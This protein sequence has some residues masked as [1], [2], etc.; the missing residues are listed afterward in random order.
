ME[1][2]PSEDDQSD[3]AEKEKGKESDDK[4]DS[5]NSIT[6]LAAPLPARRVSSLV[7][8]DLLLMPHLQESSQYPGRPLFPDS[9]SDPA[10]RIAK[11]P[12]E[13]SQASPVQL[14]SPARSPLATVSDFDAGGEDNAL[15]VPAGEDGKRKRRPADLPTLITLENAANHPLLMSPTEA[16]IRESLERDASRRRLEMMTATATENEK[17]DD[18]MGSPSSRPRSPLPL[19]EEGE[20]EG[21]AILEENI[22]ERQSVRSKTAAGTTRRDESSLAAA[23]QGLAGHPS[24]TPP[25]IPPQKPRPLSEGKAVEVEDRNIVINTKEFGKGKSLNAILKLTAK[26]R[27]TVRPIQP[28]PLFILHFLTFLLCT[29]SRICASCGSKSRWKRPRNTASRFPCTP[30]S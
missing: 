3:P 8:S 2:N 30:T 23:P 11:T 19:F 13:A 26:Q 28:P 22:Q 6:S 5:T 16:R 25:D 21:T 10:P 9:P 18:I 24:E 17:S 1:R 15:A 20:E 7:D 4:E 14:G 27:Q 29:F 12:I